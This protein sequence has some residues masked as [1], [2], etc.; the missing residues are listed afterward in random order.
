MD[1]GNC[2]IL[3]ILMHEHISIILELVILHELALAAA[4]AA[5][6]TKDYIYDFLWLK[7]LLRILFLWN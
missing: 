5:F 2:S 3:K 1:S 6:L 4:A 7:L